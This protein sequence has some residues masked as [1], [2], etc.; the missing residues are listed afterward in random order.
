MH[1]EYVSIKSP[2]LQSPSLTKNVKEHRPWSYSSP[3]WIVVWGCKRA[4][5]RSCSVILRSCYL[6]KQRQISEKKNKRAT[7]IHSQVVFTN[8]HTHTKPLT[9][10]L[11]PGCGSA[12]FSYPLLIS[13]HPLLSFTHS[14]LPLSSPLLFFIY[15]F[16]IF[17]VLRFSRSSSACMSNSTVII[18]VGMFYPPVCTCAPVRPSSM[19]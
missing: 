12:L 16:Y 5:Q 6:Y 10:Q 3:C 14:L 11:Q 13:S 19:S 18:T 8:T 15:F 9:R 17:I 4:R 7:I 2:Q 1:S